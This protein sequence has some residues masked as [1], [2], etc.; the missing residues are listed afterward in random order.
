M[1]RRGFLCSRC[2]LERRDWAFE[3]GLD[4]D[5]GLR[6]ERHSACWIP[7]CLARRD[8][9]GMQEWVGCFNERPFSRLTQRLLDD[10]VVVVNERYHSTMAGGQ[11]RERVEQC[12]CGLARER[13][14]DVFMELRRVVYPLGSR[15]ALV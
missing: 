14:V 12:E 7:F 6:G 1:P 15:E 9:E 11:V 4:A 13:G 8:G 2:K 5:C 10:S 3:E